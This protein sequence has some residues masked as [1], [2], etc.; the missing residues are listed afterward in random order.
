M[1]RFGLESDSPDIQ[2]AIRIL[3][4]GEPLP[5]DLTTRLLQQGINPADLEDT[6]GV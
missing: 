5:V 1:N 3:R 6:Y 2:D 4:S